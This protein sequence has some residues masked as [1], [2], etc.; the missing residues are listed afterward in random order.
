[1]SEA[2]QWSDN[3]LVATVGILPLGIEALYQKWKGSPSPISD[4]I[5]AQTLY[6]GYVTAIRQGGEGSPVRSDDFSGLEKRL[7]DEEIVLGVDT[8][9]GK[10]GDASGLSPVVQPDPRTDVGSN[11]LKDAPK[12]T[13][14]LYWIKLGVVAV[15]A[16]LIV[17]QLSNAMMLR[18]ALIAR[19]TRGV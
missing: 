4:V 14:E 10:V 7:T 5:P 9:Y 15:I 2:A 1:M 6:D 17:S 11:I 13:D 18:S 19:E 16:G 12:A 3:L 8:P